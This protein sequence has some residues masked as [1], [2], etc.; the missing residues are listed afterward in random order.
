M[1]K[2]DMFEQL[3]QSAGF[4]DVNPQNAWVDWHRLAPELTGGVLPRLI[5]CVVGNDALIS[6]ARA[7]LAQLN[8]TD[9]K[10]DEQEAQGADV[11]MK[12]SFQI[13]ASV[14]LTS[15]TPEDMA[16]VERH[17]RVAYIVSENYGAGDGL[18]T[19]E[20]LLGV[21]K[22]LLQRNKSVAVKIDS[23]GIA[24]G[25]DRWIQMAE[26]IEAAKDENPPYGTFYGL[27]N[28]VTAY[29]LGAAN[30]DV[31][32]CGMHLLGLPDLIVPPSLVQNL[33]LP[34]IVEAFELFGVY[35]LSDGHK[36]CDGNTFRTSAQSPHSVSRG[37]SALAT[38][39][40]S[41]SSILLDAGALSWLDQFRLCN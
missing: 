6:D 4:R 10:I 35:L 33:R 19:C 23:S 15:F 31:Y 8:C 9:L 12:K 40:M 2:R 34:T 28:A 1:V 11:R 38:T 13:S 36:F 37:K 16:R 30:G 18:H 21:I 22:L 7:V 41:F 32:T 20:Q 14:G 5:A 39:Q 29:P 17:S 25:A 3:E 27:W 24:H 26:R